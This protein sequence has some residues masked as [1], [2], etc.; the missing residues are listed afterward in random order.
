MAD[1]RPSRSSVQSAV[2]SGIVARLPPEVRQYFGHMTSN[3]ASNF[4]G[5][6]TPPP[7]EQQRSYLKNAAP[8]SKARVVPRQP[9][10]WDQLRT[11]AVDIAATPEVAAVIDKIPFVRA[12]MDFGKAVSLG[13]TTK[14]PVQSAFQLSPGTLG[15][16]VFNQETGKQ[17]ANIEVSDRGAIIRYTDENGAPTGRVEVMKPG[18]SNMTTAQWNSPDN[19]AINYQKQFQAHSLDTAVAPVAQFLANMPYAMSK[20]AGDIIPRVSNV[21]DK[22]QEQVFGALPTKEEANQTAWARQGVYQ[23]RS[24]LLK[25]SGVYIPENLKL[26]PGVILTPSPY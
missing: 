3:A 16:K 17:V 18:K 25:N 10:T 7:P 8:P 20:K 14:A 24:E 19:V 1:T 12:T 4:R 13:D 9:L 26:P 5:A 22:V 2:I 6:P 11:K 23:L 21:V 15:S